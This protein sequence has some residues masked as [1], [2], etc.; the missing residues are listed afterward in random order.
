MP[1]TVLSSSPLAPTEA[2][3]CLVTVHPQQSNGTEEPIPGGVL[4]LGGRKIR[5]FE[6]SSSE[7][8]EKHRGRQQK[9]QGQKKNA[10]RSSGTNVKEKKGRDIKK[11][12][13]KTTVEWPW[14]EVT[15]YVLHPYLNISP[16][17]VQVVSRE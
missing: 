13:A 10:D 15:A 2:S 4:V 3:A 12:R 16:N 7:W 14:R 8:Q 11:R 6:L 1:P 9:L 5:F 17:I